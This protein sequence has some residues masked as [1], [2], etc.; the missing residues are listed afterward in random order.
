MKEGRGVSEW[1]GA[2]ESSGG[3]GRDLR[4]SKGVRWGA[5]R[6]VKVDREE[7][8]G[9]AWKGIKAGHKNAAEE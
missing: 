7:G 3:A 2:K 6:G 1:G 9:G 8:R 4:W 5:W